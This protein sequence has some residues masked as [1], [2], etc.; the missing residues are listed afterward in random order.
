MV[1][2]D[3]V[4]IILRFTPNFVDR[5]LVCRIHHIM[6]CGVLLLLTF[7]CICVMSWPNYNFCIYKVV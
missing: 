2:S 5:A 4:I 1:F 3:Q 6:F 7:Y